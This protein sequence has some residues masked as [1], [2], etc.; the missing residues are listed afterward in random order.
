M[1]KRGLHFEVSREY[2]QLVD[3]FIPYTGIHIEDIKKT[4]KSQMG[5]TKISL[6]IDGKWILAF[7]G[8]IPMKWL[9]E[10]VNKKLSGRAE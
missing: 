10:L 3:K 5:T 8:G 2:L 9:D 1:K 4:R 6:E 7:V